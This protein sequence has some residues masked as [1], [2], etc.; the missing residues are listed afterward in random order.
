MDL[1]KKRFDV[2]LRCSDLRLALTHSKEEVETILSSRF[3]GLLKERDELLASF[4]QGTNS[5]HMISC[6]CML[7]EVWLSCHARDWGVACCHVS[8]WGVACCHVND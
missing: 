7:V 5:L 8:E 3:E 2:S 6:Y 4:A 1:E